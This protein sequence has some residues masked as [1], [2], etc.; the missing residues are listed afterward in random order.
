MENLFK[1]VIMRR[2]I[3]IRNDKKKPKFRDIFKMF[4]GKDIS[5]PDVKDQIRKRIVALYED[6]AEVEEDLKF[7]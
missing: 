5:K 7:N 2:L 3:E 6:D 4:K 1:N